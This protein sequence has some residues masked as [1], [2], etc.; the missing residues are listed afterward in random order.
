MSLRPSTWNRVLLVG[1][2]ALASGCASLGY[3]TPS[4]SRAG[5]EYIVTG[6]TLGAGDAVGYAVFSP[7][8]TKAAMERLAA[9][10]AAA[11]EAPQAD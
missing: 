10:R 9:Q 8:E 6:R 5:H 7:L 11:A 2:A 4:P 3:E 1:A